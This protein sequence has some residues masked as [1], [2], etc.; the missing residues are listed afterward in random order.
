MTISIYYVFQDR[1]EKISPTHSGGAVYEAASYIT[2]ALG[3]LAQ[4]SWC[5]SLF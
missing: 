5:V 4:L 1:E 3:S 2:S